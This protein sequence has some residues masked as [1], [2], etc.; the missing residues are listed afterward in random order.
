MSTRVVC[1]KRKR[2]RIVQ[3]CDVYI[4]R[5]C[6]QGGWRL[7]KSKWHNPFT[8][9]EAGSAAEAVRKYEAWLKTQ[10]DLLSDLH[11]LRGKTLGCWCKKRGTEPCHGDVLA[12]MA[13]RKRICDDEENYTPEDESDDFVPG[14]VDKPEIPCFS[15]MC[16]ARQKDDDDDNHVQPFRQRVS[17]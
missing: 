6:Y 17:H 14:V 5:A 13:D 11:E 8:V 9:K 7:P 1:L 2:D 10:D 12:R 16:N 15:V 3:D 4:G